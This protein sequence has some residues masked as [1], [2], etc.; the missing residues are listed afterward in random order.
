M[1][2]LL[3][4]L[5]LLG[6]DGTELI[7]NAVVGTAQI[8]CENQNSRKIKNNKNKTKSRL[9]T[10]LL[11]DNNSIHGNYIDICY[12]VGIFKRIPTDRVSSSSRMPAFS[13]AISL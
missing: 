5:G 2:E 13:S 9:H 11:I 1:P 10:L 7:E 12:R 3:F 4:Y 6:V 8:N